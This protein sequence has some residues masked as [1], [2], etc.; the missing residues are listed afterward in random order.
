MFINEVFDKSI[1]NFL[2]NDN[3][4]HDFLNEVLKTLAF[5]YG[6]LDIE[7]PYITQDEKLFHTNLLKFGLE[8]AKV[9]NFKEEFVNC[10]NNILNDVKPN[11]SFTKI[12]KIL[13]DMYMAKKTKHTISD[14][15]EEEF[16]NLLYTPMSKDEGKI[17]YNFLHSD[18]EFEIIRYFHHKNKLNM[19]RVKSIP[20]ELLPPEAYKV[21][22][23]NYTMVKMLSPE[24]VD[25]INNKV[26]QKLEVNKNAVNFEYLFEKALYEFFN[27]DT[28][29]TSGNGYVDIL[30]IMSVISTIIMGLTVLAMW[31]L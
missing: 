10:Y 19:E 5:I 26:Y 28:K 29:I 18:D 20:K 15:D 11:P 12:E 8:E 2:N 1:N 23:E 13:V 14:E 22:D 6:K 30:L 3:N 17:A 27:K 4:K 24:D 21:I 16:L 25:E 7:N 9:N 31:V